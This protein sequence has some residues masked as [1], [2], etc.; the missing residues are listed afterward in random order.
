MEC[1]STIQFVQ[2]CQ[3]TS[4]GHLL[5]TLKKVDVTRVVLHNVISKADQYGKSIGETQDVPLN[6]SVL[7]R[8][9]D[10]DQDHLSLEHLR[11]AL[12]CEHTKE[13]LNANRYV[14]L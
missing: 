1:I 7:L 6:P 10:K 12:I 4:G 8:S 9:H 14:V 13:L 11:T 2:L 5:L 3:L